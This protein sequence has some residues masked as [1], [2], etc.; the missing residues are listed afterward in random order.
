M[1]RLVLTLLACA[2]TGLLSGA[3]GL[4]RAAKGPLNASLCASDEHVYFSCR[5]GKGPSRIALCGQLKGAAGDVRGFLQYRFGSRGQ[6]EMVY[7]RIREESL[8]K[9]TY[10][11]A[12]QKLGRMESR[13][14]RFRNGSYDYAVYWE[15][16]PLGE[17]ES[18]GYATEAG[19]RVA[20]DGKDVT[21]I[22][23]GGESQ[24]DLSGLGWLR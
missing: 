23:C 11:S 18:D 13:E 3:P 8:D 22:R 4:A 21:T 7:P 1:E 24:E 14:I 9:F 19:V 2:A 5:A 6:P 12:F 20:R 10:D 17:S 15:S 16:Y